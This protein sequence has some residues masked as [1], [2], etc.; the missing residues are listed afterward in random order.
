MTLYH[1]SNQD[2]V[3]VDL[4]KGMSYKDFVDGNR[5]RNHSVEPHCYDVVCGPIA[6]D[7]VAYSLG[8]YHEGTMTIEELAATLQDKFLDQQVM[9]G[10]Q[11]TLSYLKKIKTEQI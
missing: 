7:G 5:D 6:D 10:S 4:L 8:R 11:R 3:E 1:G 2:I 9:I